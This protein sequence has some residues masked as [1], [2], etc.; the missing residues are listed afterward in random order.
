MSPI[1]T[2]LVP[3]S[4]SRAPPVRVGAVPP[5]TWQPDLPQLPSKAARTSGGMP[6][7][8]SLSPSS[9]FSS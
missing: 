1:V 4:A 2:Y 6:E 9:S 7:P 5:E 8:P 3:T